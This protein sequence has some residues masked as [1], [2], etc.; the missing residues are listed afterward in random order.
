MLIVDDERPVVETIGHIVRRDLAGEFAVI[1]DASSGREAVEKAA[2]LAPD[3]VLMDV[4]MPGISGMDAV[5]E[6]RARGLACVFILVTAYERFDIAREAME[7]GVLDYLLKPV[8]RDKLAAVLHAAAA[9]ADRRFE[10]ERREMEHLER[11]ERLRYF[12]EEAFLRAILMEESGRLSADR[13][14]PVLGILGDKVSVAAAAFLPL[15]G[16][17]DPEADVSRLY[18][19]FLAGVRYKTHALAGPLRAGLSIALLPIADPEQEDREDAGFRAAL[20]NGFAEE[21]GLGVLR[22]GFAPPAFLEEAPASWAR[23]RRE[24]LGLGAPGTGGREVKPGGVPCG[25]GEGIQLSGRAEEEHAFPEALATG[26][27]PRARLA[28]ERLLEKLEDPPRHERYR[29]AGLFVQACLELER[30]GVLSQSEAA[31]LL[32]L[33]DL[34][35]A[36]GAAGFAEAARLR[37][38]GLAA[39]ASRVPRLSISVARAVAYVKENFSRPISLETAADHVHLSPGRLSR[40]IVEETGRGFS[41]LLSEIR[42][43][44]AKVLL[45]DPGASVKQVS[46]EC[47]YPDPNYFA[48]LF[49]KVTGYTPTAFSAILREERDANP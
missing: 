1:G 15:P 39:A 43:E 18:K 3:I 13:Y 29:L 37:F 5:R 19:S 2:A 21:L 11:E 28:L 22:L 45:A 49:K 20:E 35:S 17:P 10:L 38:S 24:A 7:L 16:S 33:E 42:L 31:G 32:D 48:R 47:G 8:A 30:R 40:L 41:N 14:R 34:L 27:A 36:A 4:W 23:A 6:I 25:N 12:V 46:S 44:R 9:F 26:N